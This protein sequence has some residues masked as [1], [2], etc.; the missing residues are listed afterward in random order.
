MAK[1]KAL[2]GSEVKGLNTVLQSFQR[3]NLL[4]INHVISR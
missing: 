3:L 2:S 1:C 4:V